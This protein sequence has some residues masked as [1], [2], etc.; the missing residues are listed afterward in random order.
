MKILLTGGGTGGHFY[1]L[2]AVAEAIREIVAERKLIE[3]QLYFAAPDAY[4]AEALFANDIIFVKTSAGK[5][6]RYFSFFTIIDFFKTAWGVTVSVFRIFFLYPD[7]VFAKGGY[8][9]FPTLLAA[10]LFRIPVVIHESDT[11][12]GR[13]SKWAGKFAVRIALSYPQAAQYFPEQKTAVT[14]NPIR[15]ALMRKATEGAHEFL[16]LER[17]L[18]VILVLGGSQGSVTI[19]DC[20]MRALP[21]LVEKYQIIHQTG[22]ANLA[23]AQQIASVVLNGSPFAGRYRPFG[24]LNELAMRMSAGAANLVLSRAGSTIFEIAAWG[25]PSILVPIPNTIVKDQTTNA[26]TYART[27]AAVVIEQNNLSPN[28][29]ISEI[30]RIME[31]K[32][33]YARMALAAQ[34]ASSGD[35]A[36][37]IA[38]ELLTIALGHEK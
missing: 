29:L 4:D 33:L 38:D 18:P 37:I 8:G 10:R 17:E 24:T 1:P 9:S 31:N 36:H 15:K 32:D 19:N 22:E 11:V 7:V 30:L 27:G 20:V 23:E 14:G 3:P 13:V 12:P 35:A 28:L 25:L 34:A 2:I 21:Q 6:R 5:L 16:K 26:F